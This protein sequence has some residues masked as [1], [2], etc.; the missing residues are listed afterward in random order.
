MLDYRLHPLGFIHAV[1]AARGPE[2]VPIHRVKAPLGQPGTATSAL[3]NAHE[4]ESGTEQK[5]VSAKTW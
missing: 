3:A 1:S 5:T 2:V 4:E